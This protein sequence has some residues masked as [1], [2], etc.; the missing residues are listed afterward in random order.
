MSVFPLFVAA[1]CYLIAGI[2]NLRTKDYPMGIMYVSYFTAN[3]ALIWYEVK[4]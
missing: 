3:C 1:L 2:N 4:K